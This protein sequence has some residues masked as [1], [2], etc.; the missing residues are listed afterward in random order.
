MRVKKRGLGSNTMQNK[1]EGHNSSETLKEKGLFYCKNR[2]QEIA[3]DVKKTFL[4]T[5]THLQA[6]RIYWLVIIK[7]HNCIICIIFNALICSK[8]STSG[9]LFKSYV[10]SCTW[11]I[12]ADYLIL[13]VCTRA[14]LLLILD[15]L[16]F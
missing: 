4:K 3:K 12:N 8:N 13:L 1:W 15:Y 16:L 9:H 11:Q 2:N 5:V 14:Y 7:V 6:S 10:F